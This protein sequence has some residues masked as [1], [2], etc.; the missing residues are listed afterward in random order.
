MF[1]AGRLAE[2][3]AERGDLD[4]LRTRADA[5]DVFAAGRLAELLAERGD[6][7]ELRTR[8]DA[9]DGPAAGGWPT[10]WP[11]AAT[12]R[13]RAAAH[14]GRRRRRCAAVRLANLLAERGDL[15]ELRT[16]ADTGDDAPPYG[17]AACWPSAATWTGC[18]P[19]PTPATWA[20]PG[21]WPTC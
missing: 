18:A 16:R 21:R 12:W 15:D 11:S 5:G 17:W 6:L 7:D 19:G 13:G 14:P 1:A 10:C 3:L 20:P 4:E 8:A 9:G 2:L